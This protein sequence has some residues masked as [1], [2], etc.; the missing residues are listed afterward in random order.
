MTISVIYPVTF[1]PIIFRLRVIFSKN[2]FLEYKSLFLEYKH[3]LLE[4]KSLFVE[5]SIFRLLK[6]KLLWTEKCIWMTLF[7]KIITITITS[8]V[9][10]VTLCTM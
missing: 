7:V 6:K 2:L 10:S 4:N 1:H 9:T 3:L 8:K 5:N